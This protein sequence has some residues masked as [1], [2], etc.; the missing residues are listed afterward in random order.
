MMP[1]CFKHDGPALDNEESIRHRGCLPRVLQ[2]PFAVITILALG[3]ALTGC[4]TS[5]KY[6]MAKADTPAAKPLDWNVSVPPAELTLKT[7]IVFK[8]PGSWKREA[9]WDE[10]VVQCAN[11]GSEPLMLDSATLID[12]L[13]A[14]Q[15]P[16]SDPWALE[17][18][19]Y[20]NWDKYGKTGLKLLAGAG[21]V[22]VYGGFA[23]SVALSGIM[24]GAT[25]SSGAVFAANAIPIVAVVD[26]AAVAVMN[27]NNKK[28]VMAE[29]DRRRLVL[30]VR[31]APGGVAEGSLFFPMTPGPQRLIVHGRIGS[32]PLD[33][34]L[35]L[36]PLAGLHLKPKEEKAK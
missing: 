17:K 23:T 30:P 31:V 5:K 25:A 15:V 2:G 14:P 24:G 26:V 7:L 21:A 13:G 6:K 20:T 12:L 8:G 35:E 10:Y 32:Q 9:R 29:F 22:V 11:H 27:H 4:V 28:K 3:L 18:Q 16:G 36:K 34:I 19:S 33:L 1:A